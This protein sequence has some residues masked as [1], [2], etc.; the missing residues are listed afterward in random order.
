[1]CLQWQMYSWSARVLQEAR[2][3][4]AALLHAAS[5]RGVAAWCPRCGLSPERD[6]GEQPLDCAAPPRS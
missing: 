1:M 2:D 5:I 6:P 4:P 3:A